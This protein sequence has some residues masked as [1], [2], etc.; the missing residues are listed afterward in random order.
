[1]SISLAKK[2][3]ESLSPAELIPVATN[4]TFT[5][6]WLPIAQRLNLQLVCQLPYLV[7]RNDEERHSLIKELQ[8]VQRFIQSMPDS[9][10]VESVVPRIKRIID[11]LESGS[12][13]ECNYSFG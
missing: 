4:Q 5:K 2:R 1:M 13:I 3:K 6:V 7:L 8:I 9:P 12:C 11:T 10:L